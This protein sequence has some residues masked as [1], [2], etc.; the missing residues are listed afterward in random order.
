MRQELGRKERMRVDKLLRERRSANVT[1]GKDKVQWFPH[2]SATLLPLF[3]LPRF[4]R[5]SEV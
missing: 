3:S 5:I 4:F 1:A 2:V